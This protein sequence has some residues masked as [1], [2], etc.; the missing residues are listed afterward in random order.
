MALFIIMMLFIEVTT[1]VLLIYLPFISYLSSEN[2]KVQWGH[3]IL[4]NAEIINA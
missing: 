1:K 2:E 3:A 4:I